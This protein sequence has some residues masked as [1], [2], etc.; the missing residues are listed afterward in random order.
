MVPYV[1]YLITD[2][3]DT[4]TSNYRVNRTHD[5]FKIKLIWLVYVKIKQYL[6]SL[7]RKCIHGGL[8]SIVYWPFPTGKLSVS[9]LLMYHGWATRYD[10]TKEM[11]HRSGTLD[12]A[13][14]SAY[15][16]TNILGKKRNNMNDRDYWI[17]RN[18]PDIFVT[19][20]ETAILRV[21]LT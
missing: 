1:T 10:Y 9:R 3:S 16:H 14:P 8:R 21:N 6:S 20:R 5:A 2:V 15:T 18:L 17:I 13:A 19:L 11:R 12:Y 7:D 4:N